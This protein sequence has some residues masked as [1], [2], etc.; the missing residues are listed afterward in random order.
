[1]PGA[2]CGELLPCQ[3]LVESD[4][5]VGGIG[6]EGAVD[7]GDEVM[8]CLGGVGGDGGAQG[9]D[10]LGEGEAVSGQGVLQDAAG[11][12]VGQAENA[13]VGGGGG[14]GRGGLLRFCSFGKG[15]DEMCV[16]A[17]SSQS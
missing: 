17:A 8:R 1:M 9:G 10:L 12:V 6:L 16:A 13:R 4:A 11:G 7:L 5:D 15:G 14:A 3:Q 2:V